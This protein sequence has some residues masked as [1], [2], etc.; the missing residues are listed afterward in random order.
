MSTTTHPP[1]PSTT[2]PNPP[3]T[4]PPK[5]SK[6]TGW[7]WLLAV[8]AIGGLAWY[9]YVPPTAGGPNAGKKG[10]KGGKGGG[11]DV[12]VAVAKAHR[13]NIPVYLDG[14]GSVTP[15]YTVTG[16]TRVDGQLM[17]IPVK[18]GDMVKENDLIAQVDPRPF[19]VMLEQAEGNMAH[20]QALLNNARLDLQR[21]KTL[22]AQD[23]IPEQQLA[24]QAALVQQY[25][26]NIKTDQAAID[27]AK[28][29]QTYAKVT[30]PI[31]GRVGLRLVDPGN[32][33]HA[34]DTT[35]IVSIAQIQP[36]AVLFTI[37]EDSLPS[38]LKKLRAGVTLPV[39]AY[40]RDKTE[41]LSSG[42]LLTVDNT[43]DPTTGTSKLKAIF[44]NTDSA[45]FPNQFVNIRLLV[46]TQINQVVVPE[47]AVQQGANGPFVYTVGDD[48]RVKVQPVK[49]GITEGSDAQILD[50]VSEGDTVVTDGTD[51]LQTGSRVRI[52]T[53][54]GA[55]SGAPG[56]KKKGGA[57]P[58]A[59]AAG[60]A[61]PAAGAPATER[62]LSGV[63]PNQT[64]GQDPGTH[65]KGKKKSQ[66]Q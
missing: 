21:Y 65:Q 46:D 22:L 6:H 40:N 29:Q 62:T 13:G 66:D 43:I 16:R 4:V 60:A 34:S 41:K 24:T 27:N 47:V 59:G 14:L 32:I 38:V 44:P 19:D 35:G 18:E 11:G 2:H 63:N 23:A 42:R 31:S 17:S 51:K 15:F 20:D 56:K 9:L 58:P 28:L 61:H 39:E 12:P 48:A 7:I 33:V 30:A 36:I 52:R 1:L 50:G 64:G 26:G 54:G 53:L 37:P 5:K 57:T 49:P 45:L 10:G 55:G 3:G 8:L 25:E